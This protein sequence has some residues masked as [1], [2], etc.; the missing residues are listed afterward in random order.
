MLNKEILAKVLTKNNWGIYLKNTPLE[1][2]NTDN[3]G[4]IYKVCELNIDKLVEEYNLTIT[5]EE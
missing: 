4:V 2:I 1:E 5:K 3:I